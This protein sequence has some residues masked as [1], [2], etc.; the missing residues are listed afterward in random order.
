MKNKI[1]LIFLF[2][3]IIVVAT[4]QAQQ[5]SGLPGR[6]RPANPMQLSSALPLE[7][8]WCYICFELEILDDELPKLRKIYQDAYNSR[9]ELIEKSKGDRNIIMSGIKDIKSR[10][11]EELKKALT[12]EQW[13]KFTE[14]EKQSRL[15]MQM[16]P[17]MQMPPQLPP[18]AGRGPEP[19][20]ESND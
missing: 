15:I 16:D 1:L 7:A 8:S 6:G 14:W 12:E 9:K 5:Q 18:E 20:S 10:L 3:I 11:D 13:K 17:R 2:I 4:T 19:P